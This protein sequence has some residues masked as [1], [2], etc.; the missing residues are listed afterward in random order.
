IVFGIVGGVFCNVAVK[1][2]HL[3][4]FDDALDVF[5]VHGVGGICGNIL[6]GIFAQK[7]VAAL[8]GEIIKGGWLDG[9]WVQ[10]LYQIADSCAGLA[11]SFCI[12]Y[13][14]L[15]LMDKVPGLSLRIDPDSEHLGIDEAELGELAY[16]HVDRVANMIQLHNTNVTNAISINHGK[17]AVPIMQSNNQYYGDSIH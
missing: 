14:I 16:Y 13:I 4:D 2:K 1:L 7:D 15:F 11:Y 3:L 10:V 8:S 5:A 12:T 6:T 9:N 17:N